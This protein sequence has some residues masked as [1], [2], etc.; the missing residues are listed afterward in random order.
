MELINLITIFLIIDFSQ[1]H[2]LIIKKIDC[3]EA[4][5]KKNGYNH[6]KFKTGQQLIAIILI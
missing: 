2:N 4:I 1:M 3:F 5:K 6:L